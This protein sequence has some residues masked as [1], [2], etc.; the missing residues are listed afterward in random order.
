M[1]DSDSTAG[2]TTFERQTVYIRR[3]VGHESSPAVPLA[4][5]LLAWYHYVVAGLDP[6]HQ[7]LTMQNATDLLRDLYMTEEET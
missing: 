4:A 2:P 3:W 5:E 1:T 7:I 6:E